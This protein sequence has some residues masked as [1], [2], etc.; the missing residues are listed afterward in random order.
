[1]ASFVRFRVGPAR[2]AARSGC[3]APTAGRRVYRSPRPRLGSRFWLRRRLGRGRP[4]AQGDLGEE[5]VEQ[6][7]AAQLDAGVEAPEAREEHARCLER[8]RAE[9]EAIELLRG[10]RERALERAQRPGLHGEQARG[11]VAAARADGPALADVERDARRAAR[12][13]RRGLLAAAHAAPQLGAESERVERAQLEQRAQAQVER[14][15]RR[16]L[17]RAKREGE[18]AP[19]VAVRGALRREPVEELE[20]VAAEREARRLGAQAR[21]GV[22]QRRLVEAR[23]PA[24][25][26]RLELDAQVVEEVERAREAAHAAPRPLRDRAEAARVRHEQ[27]DDAI[28]LA[29]VE[30]AQDER[31][32]E[33]RGHAPD[34]SG[35]ARA[36][37]GGAPQ[38]AAP[39]SASS[40]AGAAVSGAG[41]GSGAAASSATRT[42]GAGAAAPGARGRGPGAGGPPARGREPA[43]ATPRP[44]PG[45]RRG[46]APGRG[47]SRWH[48]PVSRPER[49]APVR[50]ASRRPPGRARARGPARAQGSPRA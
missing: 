8:A 15:A 40:G 1:M 19:R 44:A 3:P 6:A 21:E 11:A 22:D 2:R 23:E 46:P 7:L 42:R 45:P 26:P 27:V 43:R 33:D 16:G 29:E 13:A 41:A 34:A 17:E 49:A 28:R 18:E 20:Q 47:A 14:I 39:G 31:F 12:R 35:R 25:A 24:A 10:Q 4:R 9:D 48:S 30:H 37:R 50:R 36:L 32:A 5:A 38:R